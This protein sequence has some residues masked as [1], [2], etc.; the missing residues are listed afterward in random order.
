MADLKSLNELLAA[1]ERIMDSAAAE[2]RDIPLNPAK[3]NIST[4]GRALSLVFDIQRQIYNIYPK[5]E[6]EHL[7]R[8]S[9]YPA[10]LNRRFGE[11]VIKDADLCDLKRYQEAISLYESFISENPPEFFINMAKN[12]IAKIKEDYGV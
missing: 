11:I 10:G 8:Q 12:R 9:P 6:P 3:K 1:V 2:I 7:K 4:I 5:L